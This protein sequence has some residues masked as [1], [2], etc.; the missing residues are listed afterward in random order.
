MFRCFSTLK[1]AALLAGV[2]LLAVYLVFWHGTHVAAALPFLLILACLLMHVFMHG[3]HG[4]RHSFMHHGNDGAEGDTHPAEAAATARSLNFPAEPPKMGDN[5]TGTMSGVA[6]GAKLV[7]E[8]ISRM[9]HDH[10]TASD[11]AK[12]D[13]VPP[14]MV[15]LVYTCPMHSQVRSPAPGLCP[16]CN[17]TL[18]PES[19]SGAT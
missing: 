10:G 11:M 2:T 18:V 17:M 19:K 1:G 4:H 12:H 9:E 8:G 13:S 7:N 3:G 6:D 5:G 15:G 16:I 14:G